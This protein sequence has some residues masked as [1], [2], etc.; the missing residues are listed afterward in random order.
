V[1]KPLLFFI[2]IISI[3]IVFL[4][5]S[6]NISEV[7]IQTAFGTIQTSVF[8]IVLFSFIIGAFCMFILQ[9]MGSKEETITKPLKTQEKSPLLEKALLHF[10][11]GNFE[12]ALKELNKIQFIHSKLEPLILKIKCHINL[13]EWQNAIQVAE[14]ARN[15]FPSNI[16]LLY[17]ISNV[18][19]KCKLLDKAKEVLQNII[20]LDFKNSYRAYILLQ[21]ILI[22][23]GKYAEAMKTYEDIVYHFPNRIDEHLKNKYYGLCYKI[24]TQF[25]EQGNYK[26]ALYYSRE[27]LEQTEIFPLAYYIQAVI[28]SSTKEENQ[29][30]KI[31]NKGIAKT[32]SYILLK[33]MEDYYLSEFNPSAAIQFYKD[34]IYESR[35]DKT[36][37]LALGLFYQRLE[38]IDEALNIFE[39]LHNQYPKW[40]ELA[41]IK[42][43]LYLKAQKREMAT[44][45]FEKYLTLPTNMPALFKCFQCHHRSISY[46]DKCEQCNW[47]GM[48]NL[49]VP[50]E[51][52]RSIEP[53]MWAESIF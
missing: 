16:E 3:V 32:K 15:N 31:I 20:A 47:W 30:L 21:D 18:Y 36:L 28:Y 40:Q 46:L 27:L 38:M 17:L 35:N 1:K 53:V 44:D 45:L 43:Q 37:L 14:L 23:E 11:H 4:I 10:N 52:D 6:L 48:I 33:L 25:I 12:E 19:I 13:K 5:A 50:R 9:V 24:A 8:I 41:L 42:A 26:E 29:F 2:F 49:F 51:E 7:P 34:I 39:K 22:E